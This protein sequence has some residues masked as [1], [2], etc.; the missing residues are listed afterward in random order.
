MNVYSEEIKNT[1]MILRQ[2]GYSYT[3]IQQ[4]INCIVPKNTLTGWFKN[5]VL[6]AEAQ[7]RIAERIRQGGSVG[8]AIAWKNT[9]KNAYHSLRKYSTTS[10]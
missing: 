7:K 3:E 9:H 6:S 10:E 1:A 4:A 5:I 8:R 2:K